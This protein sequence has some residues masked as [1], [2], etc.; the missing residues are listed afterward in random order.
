MTK[1]GKTNR[2]LDMY[3]RLCEGKVINKKEEAKRYDVDKRSIQ[4]DIDSIR[5][6][7]S[8]NEEL[9]KSREIVYDR[10]KDGFVMVGDKESLMSND[11]VLAI[12][13]IL[14]ESRAF[15]K[16]EMTSILDKLIR[17]CVPYKHRKEIVDL[18]STEK[19][20]YIEKSSKSNINDKLWKLGEEIEQY[21]VIEIT[22][23]KQISIN[24]II[25]KTIWPVALL[26]S[27]SYFYLNAFV[28]EKKEDGSYKQKFDYPTIFRVDKIMKYQEVGQKF[29]L[30]D[31]N[32]FQFMFMG[33][34]IK[35]QFRYTGKN[36]EDLLERLPTACI[37]AGEKGEYIVEAEVSEDGIFTWLLSQG[38]SVEILRPQSM[39]NKM[40]NMLLEMIKKY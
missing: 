38:N 33:N 37:L 9:K 32:K 16:E 10:S 28:V 34:L 13:K 18:I 39:R 4:R 21:Q 27:D 24:D 14:L 40:K 19:H 23:A 35:I 12:S 22:Y 3:V 8:C 17:R 30:D 36:V 11:E 31:H 29:K 20:Q 1:Q 26:F 7:I 6:F 2:I 25:K 5:A 15:T